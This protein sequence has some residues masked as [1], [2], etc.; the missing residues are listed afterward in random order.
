M[1]HYELTYLIS[2]EI[3]EE[4]IKS[5]PEK[6]LVLVQEADGIIENRILPLKRKLA[7]PINKQEDAYLATLTFQLDPEKLAGLEKKIKAEGQILRYLLLVKKPTKEVKRVIRK[8]ISEK[9]VS[10]QSQ[11]KKVE[12][13]E[14]EKK[15]EE[16]LAQDDEP[17]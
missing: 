3:S 17:K 16:I 4:E 13:K 6:V 2:S 12:L 7:Y 8:V 9:P 10:A 1:K 15:L 11:E 14:I 5:L